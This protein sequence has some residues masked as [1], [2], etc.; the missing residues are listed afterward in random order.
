MCR[1]SFT[2]WWAF[3]IVLYRMESS[4]LNEV[5][6][7]ISSASKLSGL[8]NHSTELSTKQDSLSPQNPTSPL[9]NHSGPV[10][11]DPREISMFHCEFMCC[12]VSWF[13]ADRC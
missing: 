10:S 12:H 11:L 6:P 5:V 2:R 3:D 7:H 13:C 1:Q 4:G 8:A 9:M